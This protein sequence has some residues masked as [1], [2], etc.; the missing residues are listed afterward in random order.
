M[1]KSRMDWKGMEITK[2]GGQL[3][4]KQLDNEVVMEGRLCGNLYEINCAI[5]PPFSHPNVAFSARSAP[6]L[7]LWHA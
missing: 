3:T 1:S 5:A 4:I 6:N 2:R 7:N